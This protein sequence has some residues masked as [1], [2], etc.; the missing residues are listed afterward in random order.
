MSWH[1]L[2]GQEAASWEGT[3]LD[4][5]PSAL[6]S[7]MPTPEACCLPA[8]A[9]GCCRASRCGTTCEPSTA[10]PGAAGCRLSAAA[11]HAPTS[12]PR[13]QTS[14]GLMERPAD[15]GEKWHGSFAKWSPTSPLWRTSQASLFEDSTEFCGTWPQWGYMLHGACFQARMSEYRCG[16]SDSGL[17]RPATS[18]DSV[19]R[20]YHG[21]LDGNHWPALPGQ[22]CQYLGLPIQCPQTGLIAPWVYEAL[23]GWPEGWTASVP[24]ATDKHH[25][26]RR[27]HSRCFPRLNTHNSL[28]REL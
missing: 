28:I 13:T 9:T 15:C 4:G 14:A 2:Q 12:A 16:A 24:L 8:S 1:Y 3:C 7:L 23:M 25:D 27:L 19:G 26:W 10:S 6:L 21:K 11:S 17:W 22:I 20:G 18:G 5:A